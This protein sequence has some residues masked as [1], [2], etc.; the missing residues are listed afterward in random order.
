MNYH[1][2]Y[3]RIIDRARTRTLDEYTEQHHVI[4]RSFGGSNSK[5]NLVRLTPREHFICHFLL[6][7]MS[8]AYTPQW[9]SALKAFQ[10]MC[11]KSPAHQTR[12]INSRL[13][14]VMK[15]H[16]SA[17]MSA[18]Q[19]GEKNSQYGTCW[20][21]RN[22]EKKKIKIDELSTYIAQGWTKGRVAKKI[23]KKR[24]RVIKRPQSTKER[25][26]QYG[27]MWINDGLKNKK[28]EKIYESEIPLGWK[29]GR[30]MDMIKISSR[31]PPRFERG[32]S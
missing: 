19:K 10:M 26:S 25:N 18:S 9:H 1:A 30:I 21:H 28:I 17:T 20:I 29:K 11:S 23:S 5:D 16:M 4:P 14:A 6:C 2:L 31:M 3:D 22:L 15:C 27:T 13:Y 7:K 12:Y 32:E 24:R 8:I